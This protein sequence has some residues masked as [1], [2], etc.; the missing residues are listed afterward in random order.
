V[1]ELLLGVLLWI[2]THTLYRIHTKG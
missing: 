2:A 1:P